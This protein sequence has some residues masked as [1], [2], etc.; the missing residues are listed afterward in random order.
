MMGW[1]WGL[2]H[3]HRV[4]RQTTLIAAVTTAD[5]LWNCGKPGAEVWQYSVTPAMEIP[6]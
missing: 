4:L 1:G 6:T 3:A 5:G 2:A